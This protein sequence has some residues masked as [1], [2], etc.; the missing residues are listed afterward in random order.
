MTNV[1]RPIGCVY[2]NK[3]LTVNPDY[4]L[5]N[6]MDL[7]VILFCLFVQ[8]QTIYDNI[9]SVTRLE[10]LLS[11][12]ND[13]SKPMEVSFAFHTLDNAIVWYGCSHSVVVVWGEGVLICDER[14]YVG[15]QSVL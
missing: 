6:S 2:G 14:L 5:V 10:L 3:N 8:F 15:D 12:V 11:A 9:A 1:M 13:S 4:V 7:I